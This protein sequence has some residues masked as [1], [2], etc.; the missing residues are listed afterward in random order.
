MAGLMGAPDVADYCASKAGALHLME[1]LGLEFYMQKI[2]IKLT[3]VCPFLIDTGMFKG[4]NAGILMPMLSQEYAVR[5]IVDSILQEEYYVY[6]P[7]WIQ[8]INFI[9]CALPDTMKQF[10]YW[11]LM[12]ANT[13]EKFEGRDIKN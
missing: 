11:L 1:T 7:W 12:N 6:M 3:T 9:A 5:R 13:F 2:D 10:L 8:Q 4:S